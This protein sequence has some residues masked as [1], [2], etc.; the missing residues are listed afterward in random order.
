MIADMQLEVFKNLR[1]HIQTYLWHGMLALAVEYQGI[2][3]ILLW[4]YSVFS[5]LFAIFAVKPPSQTRILSV[6][7]WIIAMM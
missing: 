5:L 7:Q 4:Y 6:S 2:P 3:W 1:R